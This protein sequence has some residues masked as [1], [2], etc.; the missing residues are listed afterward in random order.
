VPQ[1]VIAAAASKLLRVPV[2]LDLV[3]GDL[4]SLPALDYGVLRS[5]RG[6]AWLQFA[7]RHA[8]RITTQSVFMQRR[9]EALGIRAE[10]LPLGV[11]LQNWPVAEPRAA[12]QSPVRLLHVGS[13]NAVKDH[14]TLLRTVRLLQNR[15]VDSRLDLIG[16]DTLN[17]QVQRLAAE[18]DVAERTS[19]HGHVAQAELLAHY[20]AADIVVVSS[21]HESGPVVAQ[22]AGLSGKPVVG[23]RVGFLADWAPAAALA[24]P[25]GKPQAL[26][27]ALVTVLQDDALRLQLAR[28]AQQIAKSEDADWS[29]ARVLEIYEGIAGRARRPP[30]LSA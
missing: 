2:L 22:E 29:A 12:L 1:G 19:F 14:G 27:D 4:A 13:L 15:G 8:A 9:A 24:V 21:Q 16:I 18:L 26:A 5:R 6:H 28:A 11:S 30:S 25:V 3:G 7:A 23:T 10:R 17:G 20:A